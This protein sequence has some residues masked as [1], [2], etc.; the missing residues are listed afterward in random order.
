MP[1]NFLPNG[2]LEPGIHQISWLEFVAEYGYTNY[3]KQLIIGL[4]IA[5]NLLKKHNCQRVYIDGSFTTKKLVPGYWDACYDPSGMD[6]HKMEIE[7]P[8]FFDLVPPRLKQKDR[9]KGEIF[10]SNARADLA[11][12]TF[13][14][15]FQRNKRDQTSK[16]II[17]LSLQNYII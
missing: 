6:L 15:F 16:G 7:D 8:V 4:K 13:L 3:R 9:F 1:L 5:L 12:R 11:G 10:L 17:E 2:N 14:E